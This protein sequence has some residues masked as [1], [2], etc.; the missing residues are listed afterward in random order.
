MKKIVFSFDDG[1]IDFYKTTY[2]ILKEYGIKATFNIATGLV[3]RSLDDGFDYCSIEQIK[4][5]FDYGIEMAIHSD[6][7]K[8]PTTPEDFSI[9]L[10][11]LSKWI[12]RENI[13]GAVIPYNM[14]PTKKIYSWIKK[15]NINYLRGGDVFKVRLIHRVLFRL[16]K[17]TKKQHHVNCNSKYYPK[18]KCFFVP[19]FPIWLDKEVEYY[20]NIIELAPDNGIVTLMFHSIFQTKDECLK[21]AYPQGAW[22]V[23]KF[24]SLIDW[25]IFK[26]YTI[27]TQKE[28]LLK[29]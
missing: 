4:E 13:Y 19:S 17:L 9:S 7:H 8:N 11:K 26:D 5:M 25:I 1:L 27:C 23:E 2:P 14:P 28:T 10:E 12:G 29:L 15:Q 18:G 22:T 20:K 3:D 16:H 6:S 21:A 24:K